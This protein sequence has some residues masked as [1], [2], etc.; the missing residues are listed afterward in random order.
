MWRVHS[1]SV[2]HLP[3]LTPSV[4]ARQKEGE[5]SL[6]F[7]FCC[8]FV[9]L[10]RGKGAHKFE[11]YSYIVGT[12]HVLRS[13]IRSFQVFVS[14]RQNDQEL[15]SMYD[16]VI[17]NIWI[18][19]FYFALHSHPGAIFQF[20]HPAPFSAEPHGQ[21]QKLYG[22]SDG[23]GGS[24]P[25][26]QNFGKIQYIIMKKNSFFGTFQQMER[27]ATYMDRYQYIV[28]GRK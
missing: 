23:G 19:G 16:Q 17:L 26:G 28:N 20:I 3:S 27:K 9:C 24:C 6:H 18:L 5:Q 1:S 11:S 21:P 7:S 2:W 8:L 12:H 25:R 4:L 14:L 10:A 15:A 13:G 22:W